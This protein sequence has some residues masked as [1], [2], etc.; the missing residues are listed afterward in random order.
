[1]RVYPV[2][3]E[4][5]QAADAAAETRF[6]IQHAMEY[7]PARHATLV[8]ET[9][10]MVPLPSLQSGQERERRPLDGE[11]KSLAGIVRGVL[12]IA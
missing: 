9:Q 8:G 5:W 6:A 2:T 3:E 10:Q 7:P 12:E 11:A 4:E 1:M